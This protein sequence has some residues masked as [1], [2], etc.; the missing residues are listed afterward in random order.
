MEEILCTTLEF[1]IIIALKNLIL[2]GILCGILI[3]C[4]IS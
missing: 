3:L 4:G 2:D 1:A